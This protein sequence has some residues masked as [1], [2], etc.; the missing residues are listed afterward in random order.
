MVEDHARTES[1]AAQKNAWMRGA[2]QGERDATAG[3]GV[4]G[5]GQARR[6][7]QG[8]EGASVDGDEQGHGGF[9][10][11]EEDG[12][13]LDP[14]NSPAGDDD[15]DGTRTGA[16]EGRRKRLR[17]DEGSGEQLGLLLQLRAST[18]VIALKEVRELWLGCL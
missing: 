15:V 2:P 7:G 9:D 10:E 6:Q 18:G 3:R 16:E 8:G 12:T 5:E 4:K 1:D 11:G 14:G 13:E 17:R